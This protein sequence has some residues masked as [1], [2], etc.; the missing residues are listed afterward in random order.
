MPYNQ[1]NCAL[2]PNAAQIAAASNNK[3]SEYFKIDRDNIP[4]LKIMLALEQPLVFAIKSNATLKNLN[5][6][7]IWSQGASGTGHSVTLSGYSDVYGGFQITNSWGKDWGDDGKFYMTYSDFQNLPNGKYCFTAF[8]KSNPA[9]NDLDND[10]ASHYLLN[11]NLEDEVGSDATSTAVTP[12]TDRNGVGSSAMLFNGTSSYAENSYDLEDY[13]FSIS[14][15]IRPE[16]SI[17]GQQIIFSQVAQNSSPNYGIEL[18]LDHDTIKLDMPIGSGRVKLGGNQKITP[19][20][21]YHIV[22]TFDEKFVRLYVNGAAVVI[23]VCTELFDATSSVFNLGCRLANG[24]G[25]KSNFY[26]GK[27]DDLRIY[28]RA[29]NDAEVDELF[30]N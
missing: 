2:Q 18:L 29:I 22:V 10:L 30:E 8:W 11:G 4:L 28:S 5:A 21:W 9:L 14:C 13:G 7:Y 1:H 23:G 19:G 26:N 24:V 15:W 27:I 16:A 17:A 25:A 3:I 12:T 6:P 20:S